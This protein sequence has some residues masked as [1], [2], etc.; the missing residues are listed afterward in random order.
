MAC[1]LKFWYQCSSKQDCFNSCADYLTLWAP[2]DDISAGSEHARKANRVYRH[3]RHSH[4]QLIY[5]HLVFNPLQIAQ[6]VIYDNLGIK[7]QLMKFSKRSYIYVCY[8]IQYCISGKIRDSGGSGF[9][10]IHL[11]HLTCYYFCAK[12]RLLL[13]TILL[14]LVR[15]W[16]VVHL[17]TFIRVLLFHSNHL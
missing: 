2:S 6:L 14:Q 8:F 11:F 16:L 9:P 4:Q 5:C 13:L 17:H 12:K 1:S 7:F 3:S 10:Q 15:L